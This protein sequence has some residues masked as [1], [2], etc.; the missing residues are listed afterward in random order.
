M[1]TNEDESHRTIDIAF[2]G[3]PL[4]IGQNLLYLRCNCKIILQNAY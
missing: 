3:F 4:T 1:S 2:T